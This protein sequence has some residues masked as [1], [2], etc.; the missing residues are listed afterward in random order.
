MKISF[1]TNKV[2]NESSLIATPGE[3]D[4]FPAI[5]Q[6][7]MG[8]YIEKLSADR[9]AVAGVLAFR[10]YISGQIVFDEKISSL[11]AEAISK[12]LLP[13]WSH[14]SPLHPAN[15]PIPRGSRTVKLSGLPI[16]EQGH[17]TL[18][19]VGSEGF[20]GSTISEQLSI[21]PSNA[22][23]LDRMDQ[24]RSID[25][26]CARISTAILLAE[27][28]DIAILRVDRNE[29]SVFDSYGDYEELLGAVGMGLEFCS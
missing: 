24:H 12:V 1:S 5:P 25:R 16:V 13:R 14:C 9:L 8:R 6:L 2:T 10:R 27:D 29:F 11:T 18:A 23:C 15:L 22:W 4:G 3:L 17:P 7:Y 19:I 28:L 20:S 21:I 26:V